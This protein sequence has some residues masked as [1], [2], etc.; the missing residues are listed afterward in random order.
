MEITSSEALTCTY[1]R[2]DAIRAPHLGRIAIAAARGGSCRLRIPDGS[3]LR[4]HAR[5]LELP[6]SGARRPRDDLRHLPACLRLDGAPG[7]SED[8]GSPGH[9]DRAA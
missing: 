8:P 2:D 4:L 6:P 5:G 1:A 7:R 3:H 9:V